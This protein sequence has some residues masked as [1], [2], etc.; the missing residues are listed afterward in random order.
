MK[1]PCFMTDRDKVSALLASQYV[2]IGE[3]NKLS[4][5]FRFEY[6][7]GGG[8]FISLVERLRR[9]MLSYRW[10]RDP[11]LRMGEYDWRASPIS[12]SVSWERALCANWDR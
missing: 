12:L 8:K 9:T 3:L 7:V 2:N 4:C 6:H 5:G 10:G 11:Y 1:S